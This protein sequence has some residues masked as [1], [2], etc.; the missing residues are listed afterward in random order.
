MDAHLERLLAEL[1][2][3]A[4][5]EIAQVRTEAAARAGSIRAGCASRAEARRTEALAAL[6]AE[7]SRRRMTVLAEARRRARGTVLRAQYALVDRVFREIRALATERLAQPSSDC[8]IQRRSALLRSYA[9][10]SDAVIER[11]DSGVRLTADGGHLSIDDTVDAWLDA[12]RAAIAIDVCRAV[13]KST[14]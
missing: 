12:D 14:C 4:Q 5:S 2:E 13:E 7:F 8:G 6:D 3:R 1:G 9:A 11:T 10:T